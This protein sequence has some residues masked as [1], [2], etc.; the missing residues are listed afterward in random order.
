MQCVSSGRWN[1]SAT[2]SLDGHYCALVTECVLYCNYYNCMFVDFT[3]TGNTELRTT[4]HLWWCGREKFSEL[5]LLLTSFTKVKTRW[6]PITEVLCCKRNFES[7]DCFWV[8]WIN[9]GKYLSSTAWP[10]QGTRSIKSV[11]RSLE[12]LQFHAKNYD[13]GENRCKTW[14]RCVALCK[15]VCER[16][17]VFIDRAP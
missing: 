12:F 17:T 11:K 9:F 14:N 1:G 15:N 7:T 16:F 13:T 3:F 6:F 10:V 4:W 2:Y 8:R 5:V